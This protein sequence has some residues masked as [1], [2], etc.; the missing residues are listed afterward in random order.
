M[1]GDYLDFLAKKSVR[2]PER[3]LAEIPPLAAHLFPFQRHCVEFALRVGTAGVYLDTGLGKTLV[4]LEW[5]KHAAAAS[6]GYALLLTPLAVAKQIEREGL[7]FGYDARVIREQTEAKPGINI[8]NYDRLEK[9]RPEAFGAVSLDEASILKAFTGKTTR[10]LIDAFRDHRWKM[11]A[12]ATPAPND[13]MELG[14]QAEFLG[15]MPSNEMLMRWFIADQTEMGRCRLKGHAVRSFWDW[16]ASWS[17]MGERPSD[18]GDKDDG[19][20]L[21][22]LEIIRHKT[23]GQIIKSTGDDLFGA[24]AMSATTMHDVKRQTSAARAELLA[25]LVADDRREPWVIWCDTNDEADRLLELVPDAV[26]VR[27][28]QSVEE[29][30]EKLNAFVTGEARF[31]ITKPS[32]AGFGLNWQHAARMAFVGRTYSYEVWYQ[33]V[34]RCWRFGQKR[35]VKCHLIVAEGED[36]IGRV[37]E[38]KSEDHIRMKEAMREAMKRAVSPIKAVRVPYQPVHTTRLPEWIRSAI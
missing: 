23:A 2:A 31:I 15:I 13:H 21:P 28:S 11:C 17:R 29:K 33:A 36:T 20:A 9:L 3:G 6:N 7:R 19:F 5:A 16:M 1:N 37:I 10:S 30:E 32:I 35:P 25:S 8:C 34:R 26:E 12:T 24:L 38:R 14:Q 18:L 27:G 22:P 4:Q